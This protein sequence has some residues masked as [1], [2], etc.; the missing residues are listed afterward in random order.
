MPEL[1]ELPDDQIWAQVD[2][3]WLLEEF[4]LS[5]GA[6]CGK[7][8][9]ARAG[10]DLVHAL[11]AL[12]V[13]A[14]QAVAA[15]VEL[16]IACVGVTQDEFAALLCPVSREHTSEPPRLSRP[17][18]FPSCPPVQPLPRPRKEPRPRRCHRT[19]HRS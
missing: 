12:S 4:R 7:W 2:A 19:Q 14:Q 6:T 5:A 9:A 10:I 3:V 13:P 8:P 16:G 15:L 18:R 17:V 1:W 11:H